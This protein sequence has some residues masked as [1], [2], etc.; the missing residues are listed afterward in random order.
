M[1]FN[2]AFPTGGDK[3]LGSPN[4]DF[5]GQGEGNGGKPGFPGA[6]SQSHGNILI[7]S[8]DNDQGDPDDNAGGGTF[9]FTFDNAVNIDQVSILDVD[10]EEAGGTVT[11]YSDLAGSTEIVSVDI[12]GLGDNSYQIV[13]V[14]AT[15]VRRM[16]ISIPASGG[17]PHVTFCESAPPTIYDLGDTIWRDDDGD[18]IQDAGEPGISGVKLQLFATGLPQVVDSTTTDGNGNYTFPNLPT[19][20]YTVKVV[21]SNFNSGKPL[22]GLSPSP[23]NAGG[24]DSLDSDF[25]ISNNEATASVPFNG[26]D[27]LSVDGGFMPAI[28]PTAT[29][30]ATATSILQPTAT[31]PF[32]EYCTDNLLLNPSFEQKSGG[33]LTHW[34]GWGDR[35]NTGYTIPDGYYY[36][37]HSGSSATAL[38]QEVAVVPGGTYE[39]TFFSSSHRPGVQ[40]VKL[41]YYTASGAPIGTADT[42]YISVDIDDP[43]HVFG[44]PYSLSL[45]AAPANAAKARVSI[46]ANNVDWAKVDAL[47]LQGNEPTPTPTITNTPLP[48]TA[49]KTPTPVVPTATTTPTPTITST[50]AP[51]ALPVPQDCKLYPIALS[52][53]T[54]A[55]AVTGASLG[56]IWNGVQPGNFGWLT[57][58]GAPNVPT[59]VTSLTPPG[60]SHT[61]VNPNDASDHQVS[62]GDWVQGSP[63]VSNASEVRAALD[64]LKTMYITVPVWDQVSGTGNNS[65]YRV[66]NFAIVR[67]TDY[68]LPNQNR[69][70]ATFIGYA[71]DCDAVAPTP[72][73]TLTPTETST[74]A[75]SPTAT[76]PNPTPTPSAGSCALDDTAATMSRY[77]LIVLD[78]LSTNSDVENRT[79]VGGSL[80][81]TASANFGIN[82]SGIAP[83]ETMMTVVGDLVAGN[84]IQLNAGSLRLKGN[85]NGRTV[86]FN[87][88]GSLI[89]DTSLSDGPITSLLQSASAQLAAIDANNTLQPPTGQGGPYRFNVNTVDDNGVAIFEIAAANL[90]SNNN[91]QQ[92]ELNPGSATLVV[93]NVTGSVVDWSGNGNM[94]GNFNNPNWRSRVIW[95][96][97][98]A[99]SINFHSHN[100]MGAVL[101][102]YAHVTT[103][104]NIDG[105]VAVRA[106]TTTSEIHQPTFTGDLGD[107][108]DEDPDL[109]PNSEGRCKLVW[110]DWDGGLS[111]NSEL[112]DNILD[113][114]HSG[115]RR[116]GDRIEAGPEV[117]N[118]RIVTDALEQWL[119][120]PMNIVLYDDGDQENGYQVCGFAELTM[121]KFDFSSVPNWL[122]GELNVGAKRSVVIDED[123][124]DY[125]LRDVYFR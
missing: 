122:K 98:Q 44:G 65:L 123:A 53:Q 62:I 23:V 39:M 18:G 111:S 27:N 8:E 74:P 91:V 30:T 79:F 101:A 94:V 37:Y 100:M 95:N 42:H 15:G 24:D 72:T 1:I 35:A 108:C 5:G 20:N 21:S 87:G 51:T 83:S 50:L 69:I 55:G 81:S 114:S 107:L 89:P 103:S 88:G 125:G 34:Q 78:D 99:S 14:G 121:S 67:I 63:G 75:P 102:P 93:I 26:G 105:S 11:A 64:V 31:P 110:L 6:N 13:P 52:E 76:V 9:I 4:K 38:H 109:P 36:G 68:R 70:T 32:S 112:V 46:S 80:V 56:D 92:I 86:N 25:G 104:A 96:F 97:A 45:A 71:P 40:T 118:V 58:V 3:D 29:P 49:T 10:D 117:E 84:P 16:E 113:P 61:Y 77:S 41:Q 73:P 48:P 82:V 60:D 33:K 19:G 119:D 116:I 124:E 12:L 120:K 115:V 43:G 85:L 106:L 7:L 54:L 59:L 47:C 17:I 57:W 28:P 22:N 2:S 66:V 90:F